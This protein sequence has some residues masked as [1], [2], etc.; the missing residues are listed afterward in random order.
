MK[1][2]I[3]DGK[4]TIPYGV[5]EIDKMAFIDCKDLMSIEIPNGVTV[6]RDCREMLNFS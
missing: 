5:T 6:I 1:Y 3:T 2:K 4:C